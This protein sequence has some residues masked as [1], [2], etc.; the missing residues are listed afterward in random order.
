MAGDIGISGSSPL[1]GSVRFERLS[2][3]GTTRP[4]NLSSGFLTQIKE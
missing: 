2:V 1:T 4:Q 3:D